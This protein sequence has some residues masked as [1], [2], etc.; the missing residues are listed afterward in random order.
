MDC[1]LCFK[2]GEDDILAEVGSDEAD[3]APQ[4]SFLRKSFNNNKLMSLLKSNE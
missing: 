1:F 3:L 2:N 4:Q